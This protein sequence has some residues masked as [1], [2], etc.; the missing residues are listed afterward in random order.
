MKPLILVLALAFTA[1]GAVLAMGAPIPT[2]F[3]TFPEDFCK[4]K[5]GTT[6]PS[7]C[8]PKAVKPA[9]N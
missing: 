1:P 9:A 5:P 6:L 4:P 3:P 7:W 8:R 2:E